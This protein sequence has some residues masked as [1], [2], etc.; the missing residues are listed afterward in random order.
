MLLYGLARQPNGCRNCI[1]TI[2]VSC[3]FVQEHIKATHGQFIIDV[4]DDVTKLA[5][6]AEKLPGCSSCASS[7]FLFVEQGFLHLG[8]KLKTGTMALSEK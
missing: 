8:Q 6:V 4:Y 1:C 2:C 7:C 3:N 5:H